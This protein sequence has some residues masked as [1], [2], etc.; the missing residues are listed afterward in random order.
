MGTF[1]QD[2]PPSKCALQNTP[3]GKEPKKAVP[4]RRKGAP[5]FLQPRFSNRTLD[6]EW[7][8]CDNNGKE[9]DPKYIDVLNS[10]GRKSQQEVIFY[11]AYSVLLIDQRAAYSGWH[12][13]SC[14]AVYLMRR[15][16]ARVAMDQKP[17]GFTGQRNKIPTAEDLKGFRDSPSLAEFLMRMPSTGEMGLIQR[18]LEPCLGMIADAHRLPDPDDYPTWTHFI[19]HYN[20]LSHRDIPPLQPSH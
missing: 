19:R 9:A 4:E 12:Y 13:N 11:K 15:R 8:W 6:M 16:L 20:L 3:Q 2:L 5:A 10:H 18:Q 1:T 14:Y 7:L 17:K